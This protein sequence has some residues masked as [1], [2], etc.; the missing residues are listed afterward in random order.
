MSNFLSTLP[1]TDSEKDKINLLSVKTPADLYDLISKATDDFK[2]YFGEIRTY[3]L[4]RH[5]YPLLSKKERDELVSL[6]F[7]QKR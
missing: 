5:L 4:I 3:H 6:E 2:K 7:F 1:I